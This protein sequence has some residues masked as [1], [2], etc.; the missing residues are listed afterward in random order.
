[1]GNS[2]ILE[3][4]EGKPCKK[5]GSTTRTVKGS[6]QCVRCK[7]EARKK[8]N[9][10]N[11]GNTRKYHYFG[12]GSI[13]HQQ[14]MQM[15]IEQGSICT[16]CKNPIDNRKCVDHDHVTNVIRDILCNRCN[17]MIGQAN[18][19]IEVLQSAIDYIVK[20]KK[21]PRLLSI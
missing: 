10:R 11:P 12:N 14:M 3:T 5:C 15:Y 21:T 18:D 9:E 6:R 19:N 20:H 17:V 16:I 13:N 1:M 7:A 8:W 4:Y 2:N